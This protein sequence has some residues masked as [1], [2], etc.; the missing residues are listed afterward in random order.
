MKNWRQTIKTF[1]IDSRF[2]DEYLLSNFFNFVPVFWK[3]KF[4]LRANVLILIY[5]GRN[6]FN[7]R[8]WPVQLGTPWNNCSKIDAKPSIFVQLTPV[9]LTNVITYL[10]SKSFNFVPVFW[11][12]KFKLRAN[13]LILFYHARNKSNQRSGPVHLDTP[14]NN[15]WRIDVKQSKLVQLSPGFWRIWWHIFCLIPSIIPSENA[16]FS[17]FISSLK[18]PI[19]QKITWYKIYFLTLRIDIKR[20][21]TNILWRVVM[22]EDLAIRATT[23]Q[24]HF[25]FE[26][27]N[28]MQPT[29]LHVYTKCNLLLIL[30]A[31]SGL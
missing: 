17:I 21:I 24:M 18:K 8:Y 5:H 2:F 7:Q 11:K 22:I 16:K 13:F 4:K 31:N 1:P 26:P 15:C 9:F 10:L 27:L 12:I 28:R 6:R 14:W 29:T 30:K 19:F 20:K 3:I 25:R 23:F